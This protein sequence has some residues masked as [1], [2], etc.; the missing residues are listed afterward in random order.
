MSRL[1][2]LVRVSLRVAGVK[3]R[4]VDTTVARHHV[5][6]GRG[7]GELPPVVLLHGLADSAATSVLLLPHLLAKAR[8]V[9]ILE[10]AGHGLS[11]PLRGEY[12]ISRHLA[13]MTA[14]LDMLIDQ[15]AILVG[16][17]LGGATALHYAQLQPHRIHGLFLT[18]PGGAPCDAETAAFLRAA[19]TL[20]T[21]AEARA[22]VERVHARRPALA[23]VLARIMRERGASPAVADILRTLDCEHVTAEALARLS[24]PVMLVWGRSER[25]LP[26]HALDYFRTHLPPHAT[27]VEPDGFGHCPHLDDP[28]R[29][30]RTITAFARSTRSAQP[31]VASR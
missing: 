22:F 15:P 9:L 19:F 20:R 2:R 18:S 4:F 31:P 16:N 5:Y 13:S 23:P 3:S 25:L 29:L 12:T 11:G 24:M 17:S 8:R 26:R 14:A 6:D 1:E 30:A 21:I 28:V 27:I 10:A 7:R